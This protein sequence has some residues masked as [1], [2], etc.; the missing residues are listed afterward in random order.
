MNSG[1]QV[2]L[3]SDG[4]FQFVTV[5]A[6][7]TELYSFE[8]LVG[9]GL[10]DVLT[11]NAATNVIDGGAGNDQ[12][13]G[14]DGDD[15]LIGGDGSDSLYGG[16]GNDELHGGLGNDQL[17][18]VS[19]LNHLYGEEGDDTLFSGSGYDVIDGGAGT[20]TVSYT[21]PIPGPQLLTV[22]LQISGVPQDTGLGGQDTFINIQNL[23]GSSRGDLLFGD[24][25]AN[26]IDGYFGNDE[27]HGRQGDDVLSGGGGDDILVGGAGDDELR[28]N[29]GND[30]F[31]FMQ[32]DGNDVIYDFEDFKTN[33]SEVIVLDSLLASSFDQVMGF[34][35][36]VSNG[37]LIDFGQGDSILLAGINIL[38]LQS[39]DFEFA[40]ASS[41]LSDTGSGALDTQTD[42]ITVGLYW[43]EHLLA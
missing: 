6:D 25:D 18:G 16:L 19:G 40:P 23:V 4:E 15:L 24:G 29:A 27:I 7:F 35:S 13:D 32:G 33:N 34:T 5:N 14:L 43:D 30:R 8:N 41:G 36:Q 28:G 21:D 22:D 26:S 38:Q 9:S 10:N 11:G 12:I 1:V 20:N 31:V 39:E 2:R 37:V 17:H 3:D 42:K